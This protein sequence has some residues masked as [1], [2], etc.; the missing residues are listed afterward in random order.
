MEYDVIVIG[1][2]FSAAGFLSGYKG[3]ALVLERRNH[4]GYE[5]ISALRFGTFGKAPETDEGKALLSELEKRGDFGKFGVKVLDFASTLYSKLLG[6]DV[7][8]GMDIL[9]IKKTDGGFEISVI[10]L[11]GIEKFTAKKVIDTTVKPCMIKE[12]SINML[13]CRPVSCTKPLPK[14]DN[15]T[16]SE[17]GFENDVIVKFALPTEADHI[18]A[19]GAIY[20]YTVSDD[21]KTFSEE[22]KAPGFDYGKIKPEDLTD[23]IVENIAD[24]FDIT[25]KEKDILTEKDG[26]V[27][28]TSVSYDNPIIAYDEGVK[29][30]KGGIK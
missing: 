20:N 24:E 27:Y 14:A 19:R 13:V 30:A 21:F 1:A 29:Y 8:F 22:E 16:V 26:I 11:N 17:S 7:L 2:T 4:A 15:V 12:K 23:F 25:T 9:D 3:K 10:G 5:F 18:A 28:L 6:K